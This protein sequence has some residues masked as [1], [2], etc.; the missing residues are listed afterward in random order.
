MILE[1]GGIG[2]E[3]RSLLL[4][5]VQSFDAPCFTFVPA[6]VTVRCHFPRTLK[7]RGPIVSL[8]IR[9]P[10]FPDVDAT[11]VLQRHRSVSAMSFFE[12]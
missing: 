3:G 10:H 12:T 2:S 6:K 5:D 4:V 11:P 9:R 8:M 1:G 7:F